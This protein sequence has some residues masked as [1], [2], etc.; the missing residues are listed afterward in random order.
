[1]IRH[2]SHPA[3][4]PKFSAKCTIDVTVIVDPDN[5]HILIRR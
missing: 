3:R 1:M 4:L 2:R 5:H